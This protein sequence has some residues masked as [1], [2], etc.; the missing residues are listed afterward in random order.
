MDFSERDFNLSVLFAVR[1]NRIAHNAL[2][3]GCS[4]AKYFCLKYSQVG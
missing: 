3:G 2:S 4:N 1:L